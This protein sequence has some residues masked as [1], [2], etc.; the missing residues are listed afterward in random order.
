M[1]WPLRAA[2][3]EAAAAAVE[4]GGVA[5]SRHLRQPRK[6]HLLQPAVPVSS[7]IV[8]DTAAGAPKV[9]S[10]SVSRWLSAL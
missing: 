7:A 9:G 8:G 5:S 1:C 3:V 2:A 4:V 6:R 10:A